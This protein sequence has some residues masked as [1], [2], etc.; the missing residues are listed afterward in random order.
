MPKPQAPKR[1]T[2]KLVLQV[3]A[4]IFAGI[5]MLGASD[6]STRFDHLGHQLM[7]TCSCGEILLECNHV[8][9][10]NSGPMITELHNLLGQAAGTGGGASGGGMTNASI[11][12]WFANKY[13]PV[14]LAAPIRGGFD[15]VAWIMP[16]AVLAMGIAAVFYFLRLWKQRH[17]HAAFADASAASPFGTAG[18]SDLRDRIRRDTNFE[19]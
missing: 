5:T 15:L 4:L 18:G 1:N 8:G 9:C 11:L 16:F 13:G 17:A 6:P 19:P 3:S 12:N 2:P 10:P 14:V 7:C